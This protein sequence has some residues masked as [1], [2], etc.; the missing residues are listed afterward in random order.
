LGKGRNQDYSTDEKSGQVKKLKGHI[1]TLEHEIKR[2][3]SELRTYEKAL[4]KNV[5]FLKE[6]TQN[7][8]LEEL[9]SGANEELNLQQINEKKND[10]FEQMRIKW[11]CHVCR[12]GIMKF[13]SIPKGD[14]TYYFRKCSL[15]NCKNR[16]ET[17]LLEGNVDR[18][19]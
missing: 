8:S 1:K 15:V 2:L 9:I 6:R 17:K 13:I 11:E 14:D 19:L 7:V 4:H 12:V 18:G 5:T 16:T 3:K 10:S